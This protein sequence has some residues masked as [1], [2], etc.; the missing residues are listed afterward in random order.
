MRVDNVK[1]GRRFVSLF[2]FFL[3]TMGGIGAQA[4]QTMRLDVL[5]SLQEIGLFIGADC[6]EDVLAA[7]DYGTTRNR[8]RYGVYAEDGASALV[9]IC[10]AEGACISFALQIDGAMQ[11][12][13]AENAIKAFLRT[14]EPETFDEGKAEEALKSMKAIQAYHV[15]LS[16]QLD[17]M[18]G[19]DGAPDVYA[20]Y[21]TDD[22]MYE[23]TDK[24]F[25]ATARSE[26]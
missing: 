16:K 4:D 26:L 20:S 22:W 8:V 11:G 7:A 6:Q 25:F 19:T 1:Y 24:F 15:R 14:I 9:Q 5:E 3:I 18:N 13:T 17:A 21:F 12:E 2:L 23:W 10:D